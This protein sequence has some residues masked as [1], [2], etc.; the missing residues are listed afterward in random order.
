MADLTITA[1]NVAIANAGVTTRKVQ[2]GEAVTA[3]QVGYLSSNKYYLA[4]ADALATANAAGIFL[5]NA[6][7]D[8]YA[9]LATAGT[10]NIG[11]TLTVGETYVVSTTAGGIAPIADLLSGDFTTV[12]FIADDAAEGTLNIL[13]SGVAKA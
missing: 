3:G 11:A 2:V 5:T 13:V 12:L 10:I 4:D 1:A 7:L 6:A 8:G 9:I